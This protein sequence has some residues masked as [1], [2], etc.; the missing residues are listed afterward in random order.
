MTQVN[1]EFSVPSADSKEVCRLLKSQ[2]NVILSGPPGVGKS[3]LMLEVKHWFTS[4][5]SSG[6]AYNPRKNENPFPKVGTNTNDD[7]IP[8]FNKKDRKAWDITFH[9]GTKYK[10][11]LRGI[12]PTT[13]GKFQ[14]TSGPFYEALVHA[15]KPDCASLLII[16]EFNRGPA[17]AIFGDLL[18][19]IEP[20]KRLSREGKITPKS[21]SIFTL[22][23]EG[24]NKAVHLPHDLYILA[25]MN[26][27]DTSVE[28]IDVAF[29]RRFQNFRMEPKYN[30]LLDY[31][32][33]T[34]K[35]TLPEIPQD[36]SDIYLSLVRTLISINSFISWTKGDEFQIGH[37]V[38]M[39]ASPE[40]VP[41]VP[42]A[43]AKFSLDCW[44]KIFANLKEIYYGDSR[45]LAELLKTSGNFFNLKEKFIGEGH[46]SRLEV[47][48][49]L[50]PE[51]IYTFLRMVS[52]NKW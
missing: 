11:F 24:K 14:V 41:K 35:D 20:D 44:S 4:N 43:A 8:G 15:T 42:E 51:N 31:F 39:L 30:V 2:H 21:L 19:A 50:T 49:Q 18:A 6:P 7:F 22:D 13:D 37:G 52:L 47:E 36:F 16:D 34:E 23:D 48:K 27:A 32:S 1:G 40:G 12:S 10:D 38:V 33:I 25:C 17:V 9:Q 45:L 28:P 46:S 3:R 29:R 26:E 5:S